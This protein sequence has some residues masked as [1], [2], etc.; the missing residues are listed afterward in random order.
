[1]EETEN[2]RARVR[3]LEERLAERADGDPFR[4]VVES[5]PYGMVVSDGEGRI[6][7]VNPQAVKM[8]GHSADEF[9]QLRIEDLV[10]PRFRHGHDGLREGFHRDPESRPMGAGRD[11][12]AY[13][14]DGVEF[15]VEI[16]LT[17]LDVGSGPLVLSSIVDI[18]GRKRDEEA[19]VR[20]AR[21]LERSNAE[22]ES[23]ASIAS[24]DLQEP[25]RKIRMMGERLAALCEKELGEQG[26][27]YLGRMI[28]AGDNMHRLIRDL[29]VF[30]RVGMRAEGFRHLALSEPVRDVLSTLELV[31]E[32]TG[33]E[34]VVGDLPEA[35]VDE[36]QMRQLFQNLIGNALKFR[37]PY[38]LP[39][40]AIEGAAYESESGPH[41]RIEVRDNGIGFDEQY[42]DRIFQIFQ[43]LHGKTEF[44]GT[45]I[46]LAIC[47]KIVERHEGTIRARSIPGE[48]TTFIV[49]LPKRQKSPNDQPSIDR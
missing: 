32:E 37:R 12:F 17:P 30:S 48:G 4:R 9:L 47:K 44:E 10:P 46:G 31:I 28:R 11:L 26:R 24:H 29:L 2:L 27:D 34:I 13:R 7:M 22:L 33:A 14:R 20:Y 8:F 19:L 45:G 6:V 43:R 23:F 41:V 35:E 18:T 5:A 3:D 49:E 38:E 21:K 25:L 42:H 16:A 15:P 39:R 36:S 40:V 1:M